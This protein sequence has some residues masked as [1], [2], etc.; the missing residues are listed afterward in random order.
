MNK[1]VSGEIGLIH[2]IA[3]MFALI[4]GS[5]IL[6]IKKGTRQHKRIG[7]AYVASMVVLLITS[8]MLYN[9]FGGFG[10]FHFAAIMSSAT[11]FMGM[12]PAIRRHSNWVIHHLA[13]MYWSVIGLY[14]AF[15]SEVFTRFLPTPFFSAVG[16]GTGLIMIIGWVGFRLNLKRWQKQFGI[17]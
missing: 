12:I 16:I 15:A 14:A 3:S 8:F 1:L 17:G 7:Y 4:F 10:I 5:L 2:L 13:W 11:L 9:L 6:M